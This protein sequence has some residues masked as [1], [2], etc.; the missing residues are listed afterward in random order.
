VKSDNSRSRRFRIAWAAIGNKSI[1]VMG[2]ARAGC[3]QQRSFPDKF[4]D[5][6]FDGAATYAVKEA[7]DPQ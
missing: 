1:T 6:L 7:G 4:T 5:D 3:C 2:S